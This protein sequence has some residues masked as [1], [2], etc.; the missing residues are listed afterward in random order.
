MHT[1]VAETYPLRKNGEGTVPMRY[2]W[3]LLGSSE[4]MAKLRADIEKVAPL[5]AAVLIAGE[6]GTGKEL[7]ASE[8]HARSGRRGAFVA[9]NCASIPESLFA[10][11]LFGHEKGSFTG[12]TRRHAGVF[13]RSHGG[14]VFLD[15]ITEMP[16]PLQ[17]TLL[18]ILETGSVARVGGESETPFDIRVLASTNRDP[19]AAVKEG[20]FRAD[21]YY[22]LSEFLIEVPPLRAR[23][24][25]VCLLAE[26]FLE[27]L[28]AE[29]ATQRRLASGERDKLRA[30]RWPGNVRELRH[31]I[32][33][34]Y[35]LGNDVMELRAAGLDGADLLLRPGLSI[36][37]MEQRLIGITLEHFDGDKKRAAETLG[38]SL[39]TLYNRL[40]QYRS[41]AS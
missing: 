2:P 41:D 38:I 28:N 19:H 16:L 15:E 7:V 11:E 6:S 35:V 13:E 17:A 18:R 20:R 9:V 23:D 33:R 30:H 27:Q 8:I 29:H 40:T 37:Q 25:D 32:Q 14:T 12:A 4:A 31:V 3:R 21:L 39:R 1:A 36:A 5:R 34:N 26:T 24:D 22:R 10:S